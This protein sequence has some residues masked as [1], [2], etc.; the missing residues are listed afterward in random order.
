MITKHLEAIRDAITD[1][2]GVIEFLATNYPRRQLWAFIGSKP[3]V[4]TD[5]DVDS[6]QFPYLAIAPLSEDKPAGGDVRR[7][8]KVSIMFGVHDGRVVD[9]ISRGFVASLEFGERIY[10]ALAEQPLTLNPAAVWD[11]S[12]Q[13]VSD[14]GAQAPFYEAEIIL[15]LNL[16]IR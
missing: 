14:A 10:A 3:E 8:Q 1:H 11:G 5:S 13:T 16:E 12:A 6:D 7:A 15:T 2:P 4:D 9:G